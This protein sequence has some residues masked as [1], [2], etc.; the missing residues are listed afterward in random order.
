MT[1][2]DCTELARHDRCF[3]SPYLP[4][5]KICKIADVVVCHVLSYVVVAVAVMAAANTMMMSFRDRSGEFAILKTLG[6]RPFS[7]A[8]LLFAES[9]TIAIVGGIVGAGVPYVAFNYTPLA[10]MRVPMIGLLQ[11]REQIVFEA[12]A[13]A[14]AVGALAALV[15]AVRVTRLGVIDALRQVG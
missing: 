14:A 10:E 15:P 4:G 11:V 5:S 2:R 8:A 3:P 13:I 6:F 7:V 1:D 9:M 12:L